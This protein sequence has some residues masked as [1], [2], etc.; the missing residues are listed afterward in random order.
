MNATEKNNTGSSGA[1]Q[2]VPEDFLEEF[3]DDISH[4]VAVDFPALVIFALLFATVAL[5]FFTRYVLND[6]LGWTEEIARYLLILLGFSGGIACVRRNSHISLEFLHHRLP[7]AAVKPVLL[8]CRAATAVFFG[9]C[10]WLAIELALRTNSNMASIQLPKYII[11]YI[12]SAGC[13]VMGAFAVAGLVHLAGKSGA[14]IIREH[15][16]TPAGT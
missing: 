15:L 10:G 11:Y 1:E 4:I 6:S 3:S 9:Y 5:Q 8:L 16:D 2:S 12:V 7:A 13:F 14:E